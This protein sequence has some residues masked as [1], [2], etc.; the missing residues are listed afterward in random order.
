[1]ELR[2]LLCGE[3]VHIKR[4]CTCPLGEHLLEKHPEI[5]I[6]YY[7]TREKKGNQEKQKERPVKV[8]IDDCLCCDC[9][10]CT[11]TKSQL[12]SQCFRYEI[13]YFI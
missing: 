13:M 10:E 6:G 5:Q 12:Q 9:C 2:C 1:M 7:S 11:E 3:N 4:T 8:L